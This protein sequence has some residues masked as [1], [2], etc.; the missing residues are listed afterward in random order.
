M[1]KCVK[2]GKSGIFFKVNTEGI[3]K[4]CERIEKLKTEKNKL[5]FAIE[6]LEIDY[7]R[8]QKSYEEIRQNRDNLYAE[9]A[10]KAKK[11][12]L[13]QIADQIDDRNKELQKLND[14]L[15]VLN[16]EVIVLEEDVMLE[17][18]A[19]YKPKFK[20]L[21]SEEYRQRLDEIR[22][23]QKALIKEGNA[24]TGN[25]SWTV[26]GNISEGKKMVNDMKKLLLRSFN[27]ECDYC[28]D[29]VKFNNIEASE[30]RIEKSF[31][32]CNKLGKIMQAN[33]S[34]QYRKLK[35]DELYLAYE[36][37][38]KKAE[39]KEEAKR[40]REELREQQKLERELKEA[41]EKIAK[42]RKHFMAA[43]KDLEEKLKNVA[44][45]RE[46]SLITK[47]LEEAKM[48]YVELDKEEKVID[49]REQNAKAGYVYIISNIGAFGKDVYKIGMTRRLDPTER[50]DE[51]SGA[52]VP[53]PFDIH[54]IVFSDNAPALEAKLHELLQKNRLNK[55]NNRKEFFY[56]N[57]S[58]V[59]NILKYHYN[60]AVDVIKEAPAEQYRESLLLST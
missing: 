46:R 40:V 4:D 7:S 45:E 21:T 56:T 47:N 43:I 26:N 22:D 51:L 37:Q 59:E 18:F 39:E 52:S 13:G 36:Y 41:R 49:Y 19:L 14:R 5:K 58:D 16:E 6:L 28:V 38:Q 10:E 60:K 15:N 8:T 48:Q 55:V 44:D 54:A 12:A 57:I 2:C 27:N 23:K 53:F 1:A 50:I 29:N 33:I 42:E 35:Y 30:K 32:Q 9:I 11:D 31:E 25:M 24:A 34:S 20:F 17:S 3:C